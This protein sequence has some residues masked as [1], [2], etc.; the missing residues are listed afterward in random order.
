M[1]RER[2]PSAQPLGDL[3]SLT[4]TSWVGHDVEDGRFHVVSL[5]GEG[6]MACVY[7]AID[8]TTDHDVVL[9]VPK[10]ALLAEPEFMH[11][12]VREIRALVELKHPSIVAVTGVGRHEGVP[13]AVL[14]FMAG[15]TL[16]DRKRPVSTA[17]LSSWLPSVAAALDHIH[18]KG[19]VHRDVKPANILIDADGRARLS[20]FGI[21]KSVNE[22][23]NQTKALTLSGMTIGTPEYMAPEMAEGKACDAAAD[24]YALAVTVF[25]M[26]ANEMPIQGDT[27][28][29]TLFNQVRSTPPRLDTVAPKVGSG[30]AAVVARG[31]MKD[32]MKR[33]SSCSA[34]AKAAL[35]TIDGTLPPALRGTPTHTAAA[36]VPITAPR[37]PVGL[38]LSAAALALLTLAGSMYGVLSM[39]PPPPEPV[40]TA[41]I[42]PAPVEDPHFELK[43]EPTPL[44]AGRESTVCLHIDRIANCDGP[45][46]FSF[47]GTP[48]LT[49]LSPPLSVDSH[50]RTATVGIRVN[51]D[52]RRRLVLKVTAMIGSTAVDCAAEFPVG[53][54]DVVAKPIDLTPNAEKPVTLTLAS[55][56][57]DGAPFELSMRLP[58]WL[59]SQPKRLAVPRN[60]RQVSFNLSATGSGTGQVHLS[61]LDHDIAS[62]PVTSHEVVV[63]A[64]PAI[65]PPAPSSVGRLVGKVNG[66]VV[67]LDY[68]PHG[69]ALVSWDVNRGISRWNLQTGEQRPG[70]RLGDT[71]LSGAVSPDGS[72]IATISRRFLEIH[73]SERLVREVQGRNDAKINALAIFFDSKSARVQSTRGIHND[74]RNGALLE[75]HSPPWSGNTRYKYATGSSMNHKWYAR[76]QDGRAIDWV[77]L[78]LTKLVSPITATRLNL[79]H[80]GQALAACGEGQIVF[81]RDGHKQPVAGYPRRVANVSAVAVSPNGRDIA[82]GTTSGEI[83]I[84]NADEP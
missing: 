20:D 6:G 63:K 1:P 78:E 54:Y 14:E 80:N 35:A 45:I 19:F 70:T 15:G 24:Q 10:P 38:W 48:G 55:H 77:S 43:W 49:W 52:V 72:L 40:L 7:R 47:S 13:F 75:P 51:P 62:F 39:R 57:W 73:G 30:L 64:P 71:P 61:Y 82:F 18:A 69:Q 46:T 50:A 17:S 29:A 44:Y 25:Q 36:T 21:I 84:M 81:W 22:K 37:K 5:L 83:R 34:F 60:A 8:R 66:E 68:F 16:D 32:P 26:L 56:G 3:M 42:E 2:L 65:K 59:Q 67:C 33:Y 11:R 76:S 31:L 58:E 28:V 4:S 27:P 41:K 12:F 53:Y 23:A 79:S 74:A 9:K